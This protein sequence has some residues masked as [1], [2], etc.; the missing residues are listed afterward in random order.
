MYI[1]GAVKPMKNTSDLNIR[2]GNL[3]ESNFELLRIIS[4]IFIIAYHLVYYTGVNI[5][6]Q[7]TEIN[8]LWLLFIMLGGK[9]GVNAFVLISGYFSVTAKNFKTSKALKLWTQ[10]FTYSV[11]IFALFLSLRVEPFSIKG[12]AKA[13]FPITFSEWWFA[14]AFFVMYLLSP[15]INKM[16]LAFDKKT[17]IKYLAILTFGWCIIPSIFG[18]AWQCNELLWFI[19]LYSLAGYVRLHAK[20]TSVKSRTYI[21]FSLLFAM[22]TFVSALV[23]EILGK[24]TD[25][26]ASRIMFY[27]NS[28]R[29]PLAA[30]SLL[31]FL[32]FRKI[33]I[34]H[35]KIINIIASATFGVY[36]LHD[37]YLIR[38]LL[39]KK[40]FKT[41][42]LL[43][44]N[45]LIPYTIMAIAAVFAA[46]TV[47]ELI[48]I[49]ALE[50]N[51]M[52]IINR[53]SSFIDSKIEKILSS[54]L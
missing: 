28:A 35:K 46:C 4:M 22:L 52:K 48:R 34:G 16:L 36:L 11:V 50:K 29:L 32:G 1:K 21:L 37:N 54:H 15:F 3:R 25:L 47:I 24:K 30:A 18:V 53:L 17:Y 27:Y 40:L 6:T 12:L 9:V 39:W 8:K 13:V 5:F 44:S 43:Q 45:V 2:S 33:N 38:D 26:F 14:S 42:D 41:A 20:T 31:L 10:I 23:F 7:P 49:Y 19:F 51:Y